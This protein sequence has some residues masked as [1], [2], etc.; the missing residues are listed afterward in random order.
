VNGKHAQS[1]GAVDAPVKDNMAK[2]S[3]AALT[4]ELFQAITEG[5]AGAAQEALDA[6]APPDAISKGRASALLT[7]TM[8]NDCPVM[9]VLLDAGADPNLGGGNCEVVNSYGTPLNYACAQGLRSAITLLLDRSANPSLAPENGRDAGHQLLFRAYNHTDATPLWF[10]FAEKTLKR[11]LEA[12]L[13]PNSADKH[14]HS[15][16]STANGGTSPLS[17]HNILID[18]GADLRQKRP[19]GT[20]L[21]HF[22]S[23][24]SHIDLLRLLIKRGVPV[25]T[26][27]ERG[28][29]PLFYSYQE[30]ARAELLALGADINHQDVDGNTVMHAQILGE[31]RQ[32]PVSDRFIQLLASEPRLDIKNAQGR[33]PLDLAKSRKLAKHLPLISAAVARQTM[34]RASVSVVPAPVRPNVKG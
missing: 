3:T 1:L 16:L 24:H 9:T 30:E 34:R 25:D 15:L 5:D 31:H 19:D 26:P 32:S 18:A 27:D 4:A 8:R 12:G 28:R 13:S 2:K 29:T 6:G 17:I 7:A 20:E 14:G 21:I 10:R 22:V 23:G 11:M 33:T